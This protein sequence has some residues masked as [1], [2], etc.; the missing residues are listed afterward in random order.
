MPK[1]KHKQVYYVSKIKLY[2]INRIQV[3]ENI[4]PS[5]PWIEFKPKK[6]YKKKFTISQI[7]AK[8]KI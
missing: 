2:I 5:L 4:K 1:K 7:K 6:R 3:T 8:E